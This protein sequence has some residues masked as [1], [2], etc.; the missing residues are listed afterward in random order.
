GSKNE[1]STAMKSVGEVM[2]IGRCFAESMQKALRG[3]ETGLDGFNRITEFEGVN[4]E[5][6]TASLSKRTPDRILKIAQAFRED[7]TVEEIAR[8]TGFDP[9][10]LRQIEAIIYEEKMI[11]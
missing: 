10:F 4:R 8:I 1:L 9:W 3:L 7:F 2:A 11:A 6:I 5:V